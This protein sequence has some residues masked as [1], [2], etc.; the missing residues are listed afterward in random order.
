MTASAPFRLDNEVLAFRFTATVSDRASAAPRER[1]TDPDRLALWLRLNGFDVA[2]VSR[3]EFGASLALRETIYRVGAA[4]AASRTADAVDIAALN[5]AAALGRGSRSLNDGADGA[6]WNLSAGREV[7]DALGILSDDAIR[8][9]SSSQPGRIKACEGPGCQGLFL[10]TSHGGNRR[11]CSMNTCG[12][13]IKKAR[14][15]DR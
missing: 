14:L 4:R 10:D 12:N 6:S 2:A 5:R 3:A 9:L 8:I 7:R 1:L 11:W 13:K 15:A